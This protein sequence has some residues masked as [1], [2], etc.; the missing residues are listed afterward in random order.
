VKFAVNKKLFDKIQMKKENR[1]GFF[2]EN[3]KIS[4]P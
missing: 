4:N 2:T 1:K 3:Q